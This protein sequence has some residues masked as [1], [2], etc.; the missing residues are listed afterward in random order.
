MMIFIAEDS[1]EFSYI[2]VLEVDRLGGNIINLKTDLNKALEYI[3]SSGGISVLA[4][5]GE[6][7]K[8]S[9]NY[10]TDEDISDIL[11]KTD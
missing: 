4:H 9:G 1:L 7:K 5:P 6:L 2:T 3:D 8:M 11:R 10:Q